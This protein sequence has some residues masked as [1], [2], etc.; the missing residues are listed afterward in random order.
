M[1]QILEQI[2][3]YRCLSPTEKNGFYVQQK[4]KIVNLQYLDCQH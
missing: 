4:N 2:R 3:L 1:Y